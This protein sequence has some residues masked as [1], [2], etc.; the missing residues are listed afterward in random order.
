[1]ES[2]LYISSLDDDVGHAAEFLDAH[3]YASHV[4]VHGCMCVSALNPM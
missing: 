4:Y 2:I 3:M 1:M